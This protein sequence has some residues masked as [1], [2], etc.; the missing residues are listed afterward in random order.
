MPG[1]LRVLLMEKSFRFETANSQGAILRSACLP[2]C[3]VLDPCR[4][5]PFTA[6]HQDA[7]AVPSMVGSLVE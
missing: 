7:E 3:F 6:P 4:S 1:D 5:S 2:S